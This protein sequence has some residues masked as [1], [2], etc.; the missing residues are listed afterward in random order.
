MACLARNGWRGAAVVIAVA[1]FVLLAP[2]VGDASER[3]IRV[4]G[5]TTMGPMVREMIV[6]YRLCH[7]QIQFSL[8]GSGSKSGAQ[9]L[10]SGA[11]DV[12]LLSRGMTRE[13][14]VACVRSG[15][16]PLRIILALDALV[17][18]VHPDNPVSGLGLGQVRAVYARE[19]RN[20]KA[21]GGPDLAVEPL[22]RTPDSGT[23]DIWQFAV[24]AGSTEAAGIARVASSAD[25]VRAVRAR[26]GAIGYVPMGFVDESVRALRLDGVEATPA[27]VVEDAY[28]AS[29]TLNLYIARNASAEVRAFVEFALSEAA[30]PLIEGAG[31][32]PA[33][34]E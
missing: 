25:M 9:A 7:P 17:P 24:L 15:V 20:W 12:A 5:S 34:Q 1:A 16:A 29:R 18:I 13:E 27:S 30:R 4:V 3:V 23:H 6:A 2:L 22:G 26:P 10:A 14:A 11:A 31:F 19:V 32:I 28:P 8:T 21:L 33:A